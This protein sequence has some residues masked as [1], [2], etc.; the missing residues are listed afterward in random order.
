MS[1]QTLPGG[2]TKSECLKQ[3]TLGAGNMKASA[4]LFPL[5][6]GAVAQ[7]DR[8]PASAARDAPSDRT[9]IVLIDDDWRA[10]SRLRETIEQDPD[11]E[12]VAACRWAEGAMLAVRQFR[13][14]V[15]ILD[16]RLPDRDG[17]G[18]IRDIT[19]VSETK[20]ILFTATLKQAEIVNASRSGASAIISK[21]QPTSMLISSVRR[22]LA[23]E[24]C[25]AQHTAVRQSPEP[26][27]SLNGNELSPREREVAQWAAA[28][29]RNKEIAWQLGI[30]EGTVKLHLFHAYQ[31]FRVGNRVGL[32]LALRGAARDTLMSI[33]FVSLTFV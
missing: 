20:V 19:A 18:L 24:E 31:K 6:E 14:A 16:V 9:R 21:D 4:R 2:S 3:N 22:V 32:V 8:G 15:V 11:L 29:A 13:P 30:S 26:S 10:L 7:T 33:T 12:V 28:G 23:G 17:F 5:R 25:I 27:A 1:A